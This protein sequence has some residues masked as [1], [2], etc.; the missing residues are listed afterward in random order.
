[1]NERFN[2]IYGFHI[3]KF[4]DMKRTFG[5]KY[6]SGSYILS[7]IDTLA[8]ERGETSCGIT[9][10]FAEAWNRKQLN[11]SDRYQYARR[12]ILARFSSYLNDLGIQSY[13]PKLPPYP[14]SNFIPYIYSLEEIYSLFKASD[15]LKLQVAD[16]GSIIFCIPLLI[17]LL[18]ATGLRI[19]EALALQCDDVNLDENY[20]HVKDCKNGRERIIPIADSL[21]SACREYLKYRKLLPVK[22]TN[23]RYFFVNLDGNNARNNS[24]VRIW[25][26]KCLRMAGIPYTGRHHGP[27]IHDLRHTFAVHSLASMVEDGI[28]LYVS[29]PVLSNY[30]GHQSLEATGHYVRL[31]ANMY[32]NL[33]SNM[34]IVCL[35]V[36]PKFRNYE[37]N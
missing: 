1:M 32:P 20:L 31:T 8:I 19:S 3:K 10:E 23:S 27:R 22:K 37:T 9:K 33:V 13:I 4:I 14:K 24:S 2:S 30:L 18:Y 6:N 7:C 5:F 16:K 25:F 34:N 21:S 29:L 11:E 36:F 15:D 12:I 28:D 17:R 26:R 35:D